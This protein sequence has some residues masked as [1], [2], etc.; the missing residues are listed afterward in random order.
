[1]SISDSYFSRSKPAQLL[2]NWLHPFK[3]SA[4]IMLNKESLN[5]EWTQ[6]AENELLKR[7]S[8][9]VIELQLYFACMVRKRLLFHN[10]TDL[11][12]S[13]VNKSFAVCFRTVQS[14]VC[15]PSSQPKQQ[16][17]QTELTSQAALKMHPTKLQFDYENDNWCGEYL[18]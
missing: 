16:A 1:M 7:K 2:N 8:A 6:R 3:Y 13:N 9:I 5:I 18:L 11:A 10:E 12:H 14:N 4:T 17:N 15:A